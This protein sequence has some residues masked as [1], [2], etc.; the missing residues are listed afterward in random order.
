MAKLSPRSR[1]ILSLRY[2]LDL[3]LEEIAQ[4]LGI[5]LSAAKMRLHRAHRHCLEHIDR[6]A[7]AA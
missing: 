3:P 2:W 6:D 5:G 4:T 7:F 1:E